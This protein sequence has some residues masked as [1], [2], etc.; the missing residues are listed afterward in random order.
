M[1]TPHLS[2]PLLE[3]GQAQKHVT[4]NEALLALDLWAEAKDTH[5]ARAA[6]GAAC[7]LQILITTHTPSGTMSDT[8]LVIPDRAIVLGAAVRVVEALTGI[9]S[10]ALGVA[11]NDGQFGSGL[12]PATG[13][14]N[15]GVVGPTAFY[16]GTPVRLTAAGGS[17][18]GGSVRLAL[19]LLVFTPP[20]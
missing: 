18:T 2:L 10:F 8:G 13:S 1:T 6:N 11:G 17:F 4:V 5:L 15:T 3:A 19:F 16:A 9:T 12:S 14:V 7:A 20:A